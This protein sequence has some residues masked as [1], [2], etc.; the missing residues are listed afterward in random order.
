MHILSRILGKPSEKPA[1]VPVPDAT[2]AER[3][4]AAGD[5]A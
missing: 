5:A 1:G 2:E 3:P 4:L